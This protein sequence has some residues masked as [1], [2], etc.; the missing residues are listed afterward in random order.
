MTSRAVRTSA[1]VVIALTLRAAAPAPETAAGLARAHHP[2]SAVAVRRMT[3]RASVSVAAMGSKRSR[4][5]VTAPRSSSSSRSGPTI[6]HLHSQPHTRQTTPH[7]T[8]T[9]AGRTISR[10]WH[11]SSIM[12]P[13][14]MPC[15]VTTPDHT[16]LHKPMIPM[17]PG[18]LPKSSTIT[19]NQCTPPTRMVAGRNLNGNK[20]THFF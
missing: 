8:P 18:S 12:L 2:V 1:A 5:T 3:G 14:A 9:T 11:S 19:R 13:S 20:N 6:R 17:P 4:G 16:I 15:T 10:R 7:T